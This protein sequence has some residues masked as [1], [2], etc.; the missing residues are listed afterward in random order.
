MQDLVAEAG[1]AQHG[2]GGAIH[3]PAAQLSSA[4][5]GLLDQRHCRV[6]SLTHRPQTLARSD[7]ERCGPCRPTHVMS[8][9]T[10]PGGRACPT[11]PEA[12]SLRG[13]SRGERSRSA[14][15]GIPGVLRRRD[16]RLRVAHEAR[17]AEPAGHQLL[18]VVFRWSPRPVAQPSRHRVRTRDPSR[19]RGCPRPAG[20]SPPGPRSRSSRTAGRDRPT[21]PRPRRPFRTSSIVPASTRAMYGIAHS[22]EYSI[23][24]RRMPPEQA[25]QPGFQLI[26]AGVALGRAG[27]VRER[28]FL[29]RVHQ[30]ARLADGGNQVST[31]RRVAGG[32]PAGRPRSRRRR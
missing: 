20:A 30:G 25:V 28:I 24:T 13:R 4:A 7:P 23:A 32:L 11:D 14:G 6:A 31:H 5:R 9:Y 22:A 29:D 27:Q 3:F 12:R 16:V 1:I 21:T 19:C 15:S 8:A 10:A 26:P 17:V 18:D 2:R